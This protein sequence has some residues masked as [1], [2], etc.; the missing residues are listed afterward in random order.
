MI[1]QTHGSVQTLIFVC[2]FFPLFFGGVEQE[3][4]QDYNSITSKPSLT[5]I[6]YIYYV[7][8]SKWVTKKLFSSDQRSEK[9]DGSEMQHIF[10]LQAAPECTV[11]ST[12]T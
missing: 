2:F 3:S 7:N 5:S 6:T 10:S 8:K 12:V 9:W 11:K 1:L 4:Q